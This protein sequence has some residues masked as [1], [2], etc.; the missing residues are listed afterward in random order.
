MRKIHKVLQKSDEWFE[1]RRKYPL[2]ASHSTVIITA[3]AGLETLCW[4]A[5]A[6]RLSSKEVEHYSNEHTERGNELEPLAVSIYELENNQK[7]DEVGFITNDK[8]SKVGG[9]SPDGLIGKD[10]GIEVKCPDDVKYLKLL[11]EYKETGFV[12]IGTG[13]YRQ[14]QMQM[15][16]A[17]L[18]WVDY[19]VFNPNF[20]ESI[21]IQRVEPDEE[22]FKKIK[23]GLTV[24]EA[25]I[26]KIE[27]KLCLKK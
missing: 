6:E 2:T 9:A 16:F 11:A 24:G 22:V 12:N 25:I 18:E 17:E 3:G 15:M 7:V 1:L 27:K 19:V 26:K 14:M 4:T 20:K 13:Y 10:G 5:I 23:I 8:I 21:I